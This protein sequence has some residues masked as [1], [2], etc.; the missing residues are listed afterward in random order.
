MERKFRGE[1]LA[2]LKDAYLKGTAVEPFCS[3]LGCTHQTVYN[4]FRRFALE[5]LP[6]GKVVRKER[7]H[8][9]GWPAKYTGPDLIGKAIASALP[10][11]GWIGK[12]A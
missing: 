11:D 3:R 5:G 9:G 8:Y 12:R 2:A 4:Y 1:Q 7:K 10:V 6:R